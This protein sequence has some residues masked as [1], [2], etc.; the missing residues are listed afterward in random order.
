[1]KYWT[2]REFI[3]LGASAYSYYLNKR[4]GNVRSLEDYLASVFSRVDVTPIDR[5]DEMFEYAMMRLRLS[6]GFSLSDYTLR[7][8]SSFLDGREDRIEKYISLGLMKMDG[9]NISLTT[10]G[11]YLSNSILSDIL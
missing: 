11:F 8:G 10:K 7:F 1:M 2:D 5:D 3:G 6:E 9:D 4:Y